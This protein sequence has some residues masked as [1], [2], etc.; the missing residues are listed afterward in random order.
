MVMLCTSSADAPQWAGLELARGLHLG[1]SLFRGPPRLV[2]FRLVFLSK[3]RKTGT[4]KRGHRSFKRET[5]GSGCSLTL[6]HV[7]PEHQ[8]QRLLPILL[9]LCGKA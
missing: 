6:G 1:V 2:V 3:H 5:N 9:R 4:L 8:I 7:R